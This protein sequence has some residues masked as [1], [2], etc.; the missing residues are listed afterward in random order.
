MISGSP[1]PSRTSVDS[2][3][4]LGNSYRPPPKD[5][6]AAFAALQT[7]YGVPG[8]GAGPSIQS[9]VNKP[10]AKTGSALSKKT[11]TPT[12]TPHDAPGIQAG[13]GPTAAAE[14][15]GSSKTQ[16]TLKAAGRKIMKAASSALKKM[17]GDDLGVQILPRYGLA[18]EVY[19]SIL[20]GN[21]PGRVISEKME[22]ITREK[23]SL[24]AAQ[25]YDEE[26]PTLAIFPGRG[27]KSRASG[28]DNWVYFHAPSYVSLRTA[29]VLEP[30]ESMRQGLGSMLGSDPKAWSH[31]PVRLEHYPASIEAACPSHVAVDLLEMPPF[32]VLAWDPSTKPG[33]LRS[34]GAHSHPRHVGQRLRAIAADSSARTAFQH[35]TQEAFPLPYRTCS[36]SLRGALNESK[37]EKTRIDARRNKNLHPESFQQ[38]SKMWRLQLRNLSSGIVQRPD[39]CPVKTQEEWGSPE[40]RAI[41]DASEIAMAWETSGMM[42]IDVNCVSEWIWLRNIRRAL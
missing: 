17:F 39:G 42:A 7:T 33:R 25:I 26:L 30:A 18:F 12:S 11:P 29:E 21:F 10:Q 13:P 22:I 15:E 34:P 14:T 23:R 28:R 6:A 24:L 9:A 4:P 5:Y 32:A 37:R 27:P 3:T 38:G 19:Q 8:I 2:T 40:A 41:S 20:N 31:L 36:L 1:H 16:G 35:G